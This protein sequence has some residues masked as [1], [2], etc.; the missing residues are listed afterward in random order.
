MTNGFDSSDVY[1][2]FV[3]QVKLIDEILGKKRPQINRD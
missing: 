2:L 3:F 1:D